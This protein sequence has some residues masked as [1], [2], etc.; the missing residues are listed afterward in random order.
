MSILDGR[1][2]ITIAE[3][4]RITAQGSTLLALWGVL[5]TGYGRDGWFLG[6]SVYLTLSGCPR[7]VWVWSLE[8]WK[9]RLKRWCG[10]LGGEWVDVGEEG[11]E[12]VVELG[13]EVSLVDLGLLERK[14]VLKERNGEVICFIVG[15]LVCVGL[16]VFGLVCGMSDLDD[17]IIVENLR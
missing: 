2:R 17:Y 4:P 3:R 14:D 8:G 16:V 15:V 7:N 6:L 12:V 13:F 10:E 11:G 5:E 1:R 9:D